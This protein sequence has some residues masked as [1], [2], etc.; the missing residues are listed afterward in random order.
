MLNGHRQVTGVLNGYNDRMNLSLENAV[1]IKADQSE[2]PLGNMV[3]LLIYH[4]FSLSSC[5]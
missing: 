5:R 2:R 3:F 4:S 1:E